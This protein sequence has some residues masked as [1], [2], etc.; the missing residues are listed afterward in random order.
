MTQEGNA[1]S[2]VVADPTVEFEG[3]LHDGSE[4][5]PMLDNPVANALADQMAM[6]QA[7]AIGFTDDEIVKYLGAPV[8]ALAI[9]YPPK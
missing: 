3:H 4:H 5:Y 6:D 7:R 2:P 1:L 8:D 9:C